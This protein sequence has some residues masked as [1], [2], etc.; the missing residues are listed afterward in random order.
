VSRFV[1]GLRKKYSTATVTPIAAFKGGITTKAAAPFMEKDVLPA[2]PDLVVIA[3][4]LNDAAG[5]VGGKPTNPPEDYKADILA[6]IKAA[7]ANGSE[8]LLVTPFE[9]S[10]FVKSGCGQR[11]P[12]YRKVLLE[13]SKEEDVACADVYTEWMNQAKRGVPPF[14]QVHNCINHPG[15]EGHALYAGVVLRVFD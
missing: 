9:G 6:L 11:I 3:F 4:G 7:K 8:V 13:L 14:S 2:K 15:P 5:S 1:V 10:P 12:E